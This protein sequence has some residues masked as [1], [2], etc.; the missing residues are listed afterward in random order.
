M[1]SYKERISDIVV[2]SGVPLDTAMALML[3][4]SR[5]ILNAKSI[6]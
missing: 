2:S 1:L 3:T 4:E 5:G 6:S